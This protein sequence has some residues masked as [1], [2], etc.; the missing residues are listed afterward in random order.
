MRGSDR[1]QPCK[2]VS[3]SAEEANADEIR[4]PVTVVVQHVDG[5]TVGL[6]GN[7]VLDTSSASTECEQDELV[8]SKLEDLCTEMVKKWLGIL[9]IERK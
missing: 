4:S 1:R 7:L 2:V 3:C 9:A 5:A 6:V 8:V